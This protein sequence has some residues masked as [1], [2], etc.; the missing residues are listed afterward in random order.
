MSLSI[1][2]CRIN[3][4]NQCPSTHLELQIPNGAHCEQQ[5]S[6]KRSQEK[7]ETSQMDSV[8]QQCPING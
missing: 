2:Q 7:N 6:F 8:R 4:I 1:S 3:Q 5:F